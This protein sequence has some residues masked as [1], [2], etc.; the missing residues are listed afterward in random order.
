MV[1]LGN[2]RARQACALGAVA[3]LTA[4]LTACGSSS[5]SAT[6]PAVSGVPPVSAPATSNSPASSSPAATS[7]AL[8][9][10]C[11]ADGC[12]IRIVS[13]AAAGPELLVTFVANYT[14]D[15]SRNHFHV[16]WDIYKAKQ[17]SDDAVTRF[18]VTQGVWVPTSDNPY[19]TND[20]VSVSKRG[21]SK[22]ICVTAGD[23]HHDVIDPT[24]VDCRDVSTLL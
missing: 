19:R 17:V 18:H 5:T 11:P 12:R 7:A 9:N 23:R 6:P 20:A 4:T 24:L 16:Y 8:A 1:R 21:G 3:L 2:V 15:V 14:P 10:A 22:R 13:V